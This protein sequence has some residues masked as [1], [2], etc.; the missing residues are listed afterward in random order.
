MD[1][2]ALPVGRPCGFEG[3]SGHSF[4]R[5]TTARTRTMSARSLRGNSVSLS[6]SDSLFRPGPTWSVHAALSKR[7]LRSAPV[8]VISWTGGRGA[9]CA[10]KWTFSLKTW[11]R[12][13][14][15]YL[16]SVL[17]HW[18]RS[19]NRGDRMGKPT[20][21]G[22]I[23]TRAVRFPIFKGYRLV[24]GCRLRWVTVTALSVSRPAV[25]PLR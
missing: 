5:G 25:F 9:V 4:T 19:R 8:R 11:A 3:K 16:L 12:V 10:T 15:A 23:K 13:S 17:A 18:S 22:E 2:R 21:A 14:C 7:G 6:L 24:F 1:N 20:A